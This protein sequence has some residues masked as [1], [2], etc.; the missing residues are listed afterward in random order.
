MAKNHRLN[1]DGSW[2][3]FPS[4][5]TSLK[6]VLRR[7]LTKKELAV[8]PTSFDIIGDIAIFNAFPPL[9]RKKEK[10]IAQAIMQQNKHVKVVCKKMK[11]FSG[12]FRT[13]K[14]KIIAGEKRT[15]TIHKENKAMMKLDVEECYFSPRTSS[16]RLRIAKRVKKNETVLVLFSGVAPFLCV[17]AKNAQPKLMYGIE[18][19]KIAHHYAQENL[20]LNKISNA[21]LIQ[22]DVK[23]ELPKLKEKFDRI[24]M[25][26]P[27]NAENYL[28][29]A[30][31]K[32]KPRGTM[33]LYL[34]ASERE[35]TSIKKKYL[36][37]FRKVNLVK[38]G[39]YA[40]G[41]YRICLDLTFS[42]Q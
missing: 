5:M 37:L 22:G 24:L 33:H 39:Q 8:V 6:D 16:E 26:L 36:K 21:V 9:L 13:Q 1:T 35:F 40:P 30:K 31:K 38:C 27:K 17:I 11:K 20:R 42:R 18:L 23:K 12:R 7:K 34:F 14:L 2:H 41:I 25:P 29:A 32:L 10:I 19:N 3:L 28:E 15:V 4:P